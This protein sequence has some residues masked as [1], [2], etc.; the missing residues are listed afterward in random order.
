M[1]WTLKLIAAL[2]LGISIGM[3]VSNSRYSV[4]REQELDL[5]FQRGVSEGIR[6]AEEAAK[7][8]LP[9]QCTAWWF[10]DN[11]SRHKEIQKA[12]CKG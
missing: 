6:Q 3:A 12:F 1:S 4:L 9:K 11:K 8:Q 10:T 5:S 7:E 2:T